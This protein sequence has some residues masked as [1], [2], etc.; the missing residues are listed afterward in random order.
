M[1]N[2]II[3]NGVRQSGVTTK[4]KELKE[5][6]EGLGLGYSAHIIKDCDI[7]SK[8][9]IVEGKNILIEYGK[10]YDYII[11]ERFNN[12]KVVSFLKEIANVTTINLDESDI[13]M[14]MIGDDLS[15]EN[16]KEQIDN[17]LKFK[18]HYVGVV[19]R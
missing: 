17:Y 15:K 9:L 3:I 10:K 12:D 8:A 7:F 13:V 14:R 1:Q 6:I 5:K 4:A 16:V 19:G 2:I 11:I 18:R